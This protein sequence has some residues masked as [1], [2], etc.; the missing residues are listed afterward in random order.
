M[1]ADLPAFSNIISLLHLLSKVSKGQ[2]AQG[3]SLVRD[4]TSK[5]R[6][7]STKQNDASLAKRHS[8]GIPSLSLCHTAKQ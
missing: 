4:R 2:L 5:K 8:I 6:H 1:G 3:A 7:D